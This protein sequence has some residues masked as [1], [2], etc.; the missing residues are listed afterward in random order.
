MIGNLFH[1][2][3]NKIGFFPIAGNLDDEIQKILLNLNW[4]QSTKTNAPACFVILDDP[5]ARWSRLVC[6][7]FIIS[8]HSNYNLNEDDFLDFL[9]YNK[10]SCREI[11]TL[12]KNIYQ[13]SKIFDKFKKI[14]FLRLDRKIGYTLNHLLHDYG[15][16]NQFNNSLQLDDYNQ[17][18]ITKLTN[19]LNIKNNLPYLNKVM[20]YLQDDFHF[21]KSIE[22]YAR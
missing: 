9:L 15:V 17:S 21:T 8:N 12:Q 5:F 11:T 18:N 16:S 2:Q 7:Q 1:D 13:E 19:F 14:H 22:F 20:E 6:D 10:V 3:L 4:L